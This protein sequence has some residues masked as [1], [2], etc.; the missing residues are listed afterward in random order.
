MPSLSVLGVGSLLALRRAMRLAPP[1]CLLLSIVIAVSIINY[2]FT[3]G[4]HKFTYELLMIIAMVLN[5][6]LPSGSQIA[7]S[8]LVT[9]CDR[10][11]GPL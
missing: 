3:Y 4:N 1:Q 9:E 10:F 2:K 7:W 6:T 5:G 11:G 8:S